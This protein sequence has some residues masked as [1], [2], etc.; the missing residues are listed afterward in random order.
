MWNRALAPT[1]DHLP[2]APQTS[3]GARTVRGGRCFRGA[4][5]PAARAPKH[6]VTHCGRKAQGQAASLGDAARAFS[7]SGFPRGLALGARGHGQAPRASCPE[8]RAGAQRCFHRTCVAGRAARGTVSPAHLATWGG[9]RVSP[10]I[11]LQIMSSTT[12]LVGAPT[13]PEAVALAP[14]AP[15]GNGPT[16]L[17]RAEPEEEGLRRHGRPWGRGHFSPLR[18]PPLVPGAPAWVPGPR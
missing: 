16:P 2:A 7:R 8:P 13:R 10:D 12:G 5:R 11:R 6:T 18:A 4:W 17:P 3:A 9:T 14:E 1:F 15:F